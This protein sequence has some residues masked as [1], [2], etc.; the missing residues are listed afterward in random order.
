MCA[1][2]H[3]CQE[4][5]VFPKRI[6]NRPS[7]S[8]IDYRIGQYSHLREYMLDQLNSSAILEKWTHRNA[9]DPGIAMLEGNALIGDILTFYQQLYANEVYLRSA[10][11]QE[12]INDLVQIGGYRMAP[13]VG[14]EATFVLKI[15]GQDSVVVPKG[16]G[17]KAQLKNRETED[18]FESVEEIITYPHLSEF[19]LYRPANPASNI[20]IG[21]AALEIKLVEGSAELS[22][23]LAIDLQPGDRLIL[24]PDSDMFDQTGQS[25][26]TQAASEIVMVKSVDYL[27]D[28]VTIN[29]EGKLQQNRGDSVKSFKI[30][31][32]FRHFGFN[33]LRRYTVFDP[34]SQTADYPETEFYRYINTTDIGSDYYSTLA[35]NQIP[36]EKEVDDLA[37]GSRLVCEG[38]ANFNDT[39]QA[40]SPQFSEQQFTVVKTIEQIQSDSLIWANVESPTTVVIIDQ[41]LFTNQSFYN[42]RT[43]IRRTLF[44]ETLGSELTLQATTNY[45]NGSFSTGKLEYF[46]TYQQALALVGRR[47]MLTENEKSSVQV[48]KV[49]SGPEDLAEQLSVRDETDLWRWEVTLDQIPEWPQD[50]FDNQSNQIVVY[51]NL[52]DTTQGKSQDEIVLGS[53][54][55]RQRFQTFA[56]PKVPLTYLLDET[57]TPAQ[58]PELLVYVNNILWQRVESFFERAAD[59][60]V[61]VVRE[62]NEGNSFVQF[63]DGT[64]GARLPSGQQ[65]VTAFYRVGIGAAGQ[66]A[67][68]KKPTAIGK[69]AG[70]EKVILPG[71]AV[72]GG[73]PESPDNA[74]TA[75]PAKLQSLGRLVGLADFEAEA[76]AIPGVLKVRATWDAPRGTPLIQIV[77]L[78]ATGT[79]AATEK[80]QSTLNGYNRCRG[81]KRFPIT[82]QQGLKQYIYLNIRVGF[83]ASRKQSEMS[84]DIKQALGSVNSAGEESATGSGLFS[85]QN[86]TF[87]QGAHHSQIQAAVQNVAGVTWVEIDDA[88][89]IDLGTPPE[90]DPVPLVL[91]ALPTT[92]KTIGCLPERILTLNDLHLEIALSKDETQTECGT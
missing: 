64:F 26:R 36:L 81:P 48:V 37:L 52:I 85:L 45:S 32:S 83:E 57:Q 66:L 16:L 18:E 20:A 23:K 43:D 82:V 33:A 68:D 50:A 59:A 29:I 1:A 21:D 54:D 44:H 19:H 22:A 7:L 58:T 25:Q 84:E 4:E 67:V 9:D 13:G 63:G 12:S 51:G 34:A 41:Q 28:K 73:E 42:E 53:G 17:F 92:T 11:W 86:R 15:K 38:V 89:V 6:L 88:Q 3:F 10:N 76:M 24:L 62:D 49:T 80:V 70:L 14:G 77:V 90:T 65:N 27:L 69:L 55:S 61:Y 46:G 91:P 31:R 60:Q 2:K 79:S 8:S 87:G 47:L 74:R 35:I 39:T 56:I 75:A 72:G 71:E 40:G 5:A 78:T 30:D